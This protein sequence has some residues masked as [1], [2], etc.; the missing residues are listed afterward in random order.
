[1]NNA[2]L[3]AASGTTSIYNTF[4][5][6]MN[7]LFGVWTG[8]VSAGTGQVPFAV[9]TSYLA[10]AHYPVFMFTF[11]SGA[12]EEKFQADIHR[13][14]PVV[15]RPFNNVQESDWDKYIRR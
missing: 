9:A 6:D 7:S 15:V 13:S 14:S 12:P 4:S 2:V 11:S 10:Q 5:G 1:M 8:T 3:M